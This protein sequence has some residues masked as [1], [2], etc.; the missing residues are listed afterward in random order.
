MVHVLLHRQT[1]LESFVRIH[2]CIYR[3]STSQRASSGARRETRER[4]L[5]GCG[6]VKGTDG[7]GVVLEREA[8]QGI[9]ESKGRPRPSSG[10]VVRYKERE[11][12]S[13]DLQLTKRPLGN[14]Y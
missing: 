4:L 8:W 9:R 11:R 10:E 14:W 3:Q 13:K 12:R 2:Q 6:D 7:G 5:E 1:F